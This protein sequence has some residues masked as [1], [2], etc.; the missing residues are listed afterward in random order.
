M[1]SQSLRIA[2]L[3]SDAGTSLHRAG[4]L[5]RLGHTVEI[6]DPSVHLPRSAALTRLSWETGGLLTAGRQ[7]RGLT[8]W[9]DQGKWDVVW[10]DN[11]RFVPGAVLRHARERGARSVVYN[12]DDPYGTRDRFSWGLF[13]KSLP[14]YDLVVV[15][16]EPN[17]AEARALGARDVMRVFMSADEVAHCP[18]TVDPGQDGEYRREVAFIGT[19]MPERGPFFARLV[20][21][22]IRPS[23]VGD[24]WERAP[25]WP[26]L[27]PFF[28]GGFTKSDDEYALRIQ[29]ARVS[30]G[31]LSVGNRDQ[32]TTRS[33]EIPALGGLL[34]AQRTPEH[35]ALYEDGAEAVFW[36]T[37]EECAERA[38]EM[39]GSPGLRDAIAKKGRE[40]CL[41]NGH[42]HEP[43]LSRILARLMG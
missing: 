16:R 17:V 38:K 33:M 26:A 9:L 7:R 6:H 32:H 12:Q 14:D 42:M 1:P 22:G 2:Y 37:A 5:R 29:C 19:W 3:G 43:V 34:C 30:L 24:R 28:E 35:L 10:V 20:E 15:V 25:E 21:L 41:A 11:G 40:R 31:L 36:D 8:E 39:L 23:I 13:R 4:A 18:R 27:R